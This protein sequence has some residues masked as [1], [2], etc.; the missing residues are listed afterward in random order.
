MCMGFLNFFFFIKL[1]EE[2]LKYILY[3]VIQTTKAFF[4][5]LLCKSA[6]GCRTR[7]CLRTG[8]TYSPPKYHPC[9]PSVIYN[10]Y[11]LIRN[12][13]QHILCNEIRLKPQ[14]NVLSILYILFCIYTNP[15][16]STDRVYKLN[17]NEVRQQ[18]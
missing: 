10:I 6:L 13:L 15:V 4:F 12:G 8:P 1:T 16:N 17:V 11:H 18:M 9:F 14:T 2:T 7:R 5:S 3:K